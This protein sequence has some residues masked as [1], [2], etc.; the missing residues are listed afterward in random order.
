[1]F[2]LD[3]THVEPMM[4]LVS[5]GIVGSKNVFIVFFPDQIN[6]LHIHKSLGFFRIIHLDSL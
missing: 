2:I 4:L 6:S 5:D 3:L 1:M